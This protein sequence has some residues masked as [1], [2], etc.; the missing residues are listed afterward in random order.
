MCLQIPTTKKLLLKRIQDSNFPY[1]AN[2]SRRK[3]LQKN[4]K[5]L[6]ASNLFKIRIL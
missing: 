6:Q 4:Q 1:K 3:L 5:G 2:W